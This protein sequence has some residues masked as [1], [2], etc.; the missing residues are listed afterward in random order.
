MHLGLFVW[1]S[2][3]RFLIWDLCFHVFIFNIL[4]NVLV[5]FSTFPTE[6]VHSR[7][8]DPFYPVLSKHYGIFDPNTEKAK[9]Q[10]KWKDHPP[11][12]PTCLSLHYVSKQIH[13]S[14]LNKYHHALWRSVS[15]KHDNG[16]QETKC[17]IHAGMTQQDKR[18]VSEFR[19]WV[20]MQN[21]NS[22]WNKVIL[23][24]KRKESMLKLL[25]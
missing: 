20:A 2:V 1:S 16:S 19:K 11:F 5:I 7:K 8:A 12:L 4:A 15:C 23:M 3:K 13:L 25:P 18:L 9:K 10:K 24:Q 14:H 21:N 17:S 6:E 22:L